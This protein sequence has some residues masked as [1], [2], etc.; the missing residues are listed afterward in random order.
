MSV[1]VSRGQ[2]KL[3]HVVEVRNHRLLVDEP[4]EVGGEDTGFT[5]H[6]LLAAALG[7]CTALTV[8]LYARR[9]EWPLSDIDVRVDHETGKDG[10]FLLKRHIRYIG[11]LSDEQKTR[12]TEI[13]NKCP[14]HRTLSGPIRIDTE[15]EDGASA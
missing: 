13:A 2:G 12:L 3:Q 10:V 9:K 4:P 8:T 1:K 15:V 5:P 11:E 7:S 6:E 14:V